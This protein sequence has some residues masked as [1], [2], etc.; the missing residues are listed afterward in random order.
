MTLNRRNPNN[1]ESGDV[2]VTF[3]F[4]ACMVLCAIF[5]S[6]LIA[7]A[8]TGKGGRH[9]STFDYAPSSTTSPTPTPTAPSNTGW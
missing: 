3:I 7:G 1:E 8:I 4:I 9:Y 5:I 6:S 2:I